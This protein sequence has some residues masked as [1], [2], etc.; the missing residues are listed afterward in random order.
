MRTRKEGTVIRMKQRK[1]IAGCICM[2]LLLLGI[3]LTLTV[4]AINTPFIPLEPDPA[5]PTT[6]KPSTPVTNSPVSE[7]DTTA[8]S[9]GEPVQEPEE[10]KTTHSSGEPTQGSDGQEITPG[11]L[12]TS[13]LIELSTGEPQ[14]NSQKELQEPAESSPASGQ[15][16]VGTTGNAKKGCGGTISG[17]VLLFSFVFAATVIGRKKSF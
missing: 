8:P 4:G 16:P 13:E 11:S 15:E 5:E 2:F 9:S 14:A 10:Q 3:C 6:P 1:R 7:Q 12:S 17:S